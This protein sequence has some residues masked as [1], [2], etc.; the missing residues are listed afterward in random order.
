[1]R[2]AYQYK[3]KPTSEQKIKLNHVRRICQYV[4][5]RALAERMDWW[6]RN[7]CPIN[8]CPLICHLPE[9]KPLPTYLSQQNA[10]PDLKK[11]LILVKWSGELLD[12]TALYS[13]ILQDVVRRVDLAMQRYIKGDRNGN[14]SG[15]PRFKSESRYKSFTYQEAKSSWIKGGKIR[16]PKIGNVRAIW[17]RPLPLCFNIKTCIVCQKADGWYITL[18]LEDKTVPEFTPD[19][20]E[21]TWDNSLGIDAV[22]HEDVFL[23]TSERELLPALKAYRTSESKLKNVAAKKSAK[24]KGARARR[25]LAKKEGRIHQRI[26]RSRKDHH[27]KT[28]HRLAKTEKKV[29]FVE[30]LELKNL[31]K[32]NQAKTDDNGYFLPNGQSSKSGLN[33]SFLDAGFGQFVDILSYIVAK[34]GG[35]V[36][37]VKP[38]Y[39]SQ[40]CCECDEYVPKKLSDRIHSCPNC[41]LVLDRDILAAINTKRVGVDVF[42]T[43]KR[44]REKLVITSTNS[45]SKEFLI[46]SPTYNL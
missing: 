10:L 21:P 44:R 22:L 26:A 28:A 35:K 9:L 33:K 14:R 42:P 2:L 13:H 7:R 1:M 16:L 11:D 31:T 19:L 37:K 24:K 38:D 25:K 4:Y 36:V 20:I 6:E 18:T 32:R 17:H 30:D 43:I 46:G 23:A 3:I 12:L 34:T 39:T 40:I 27:Y 8:V 41:G 15:R 29:F 45:T 5:N